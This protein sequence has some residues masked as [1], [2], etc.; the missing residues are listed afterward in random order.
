MRNV[1]RI[2][3]G[4]YPLPHEEGKRLRKLLNFPA[5]TAS[6]VDPCVGTGAALHQLTEGANAEKH[7]VEL[8]ANRAAAAAASGITTIQG[9]LFNAIGKVE[10]FSFL[11]LNPPYDSEIGSMDN[12][13]MEFLFL[14]HT[15]RW[16]IEGGVLLM[17]VPQERLD[18]S[19]PLLAEHFADLQV[20][21]LT[22][23]ESERFN[24]VALFGVRRRMRGQDYSRN[25]AALQEM[26]WRRDMPTLQGDETPCRVPASASTRLAY[27]GLPLDQIED[28]IVHSSA[29]KQVE[30]LLL[31]KE[32]MAGGRPI[33][34]LHAGHVGLLCTAGLLNGVFGQ[35]DDRHIARWRSVKSVTVFEVEEK[36]YTE[37]HKREQFTNELALVY[38][39]GRTLVLGDKK[40]EDDDAERT[41]AAGAA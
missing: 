2:K 28:L 32:E 20:F 12:R 24:Q 38:E 23:P 37:V 35:S 29:W 40:K 10:T 18:S 19:I 21:R 15:Y 31:P 7:G 9:D 11:Y 39:D 41:F 1:A 6:V 4:Y 27:R 36:G 16:L 3:L 22:D 17:V 14:E 33:T 8:D 34:P 25:R 13:R 26:V 5:G 30:A